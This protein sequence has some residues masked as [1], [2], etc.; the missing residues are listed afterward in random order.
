M[1]KCTCNNVEYAFNIGTHTAQAHEYV[2]MLI[3]EAYAHETASQE[4]VNKA[5]A[6]CEAHYAQV[7]Q[8]PSEGVLN[9]L[10]WYIV[11]DEMTDDHPDKMSREEYPIL[12]RGQLRRRNEK[13]VTLGEL[14][15]GDT[16]YLGKRRVTSGLLTD[17][18]E[19][20]DEFRP[21]DDTIR[22]V[23]HRE[24]E[25]DIVDG[26]M[27]F[28]HM[29]DGADLTDREKAVIEWIIVGEWTQTELAAEFDVS[30]ARISHLYNSA[31]DKIR[32]KFLR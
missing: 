7:G 12:S 4:R 19:V 6:L 3:D 14:P 32:R 27:D 10:A 9:R 11:F 26:R 15:Y 1:A 21:F 25:T 23:E 8:M 28:E 22:I 29:I 16:R 17:D 13:T 18:G 2:T 30:Q 31:L 20:R 5:D 24:R